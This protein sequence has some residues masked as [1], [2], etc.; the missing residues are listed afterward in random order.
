MKL[1]DLKIDVK[2]LK[3]A[4]MKKT[5]L[6]V[7]KVQLLK[8]DEL[9]KISGA[10]HINKVPYCCEYNYEDGSCVYWIYVP[11]ESPVH[12]QEYCYY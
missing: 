11:E 9:K 7:E 6:K 4:K 12:P 3:Q 5:I 2:P 8:A 1:Q 10:G